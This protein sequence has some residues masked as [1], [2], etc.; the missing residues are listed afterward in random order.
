MTILRAALKCEPRTSS[1]SCKKV[2]PGEASTPR[3]SGSERGAHLASVWA[4][5]HTAPGRTCVQSPDGQRHCGVDTR[6]L[7]GGGGAEPGGQG[8]AGKARPLR[9]FP[10]LVA[11]KRWW[12]P[13]ALPQLWPG[14]KVGPEPV[15]TA[16]RLPLSSRPLF[17]ILGVQGR[18][19]VPEAPGQ[20]WE[21]RRKARPSLWDQL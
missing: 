20:G 21:K 11:P 14:S 1:K 8:K 19:L 15:V 12:L 7:R 13:L 2:N 18:K 9:H 3:E 10:A 17:P 16:D 6:G 5:L 4:N